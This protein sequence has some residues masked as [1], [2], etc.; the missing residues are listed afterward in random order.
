MIGQSGEETTED[1]ST[2]LGKYL[3]TYELG[4]HGVG[5]SL[6]Q[7]CKDGLKAGFA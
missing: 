3:T 4:L 5:V 7:K 2:C 1:Q 6:G